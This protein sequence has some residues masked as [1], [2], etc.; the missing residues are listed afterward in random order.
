MITLI[1]NPF[2]VNEGSITQQ[3][4]YIQDETIFL[5][6]NDKK[7]YIK[8]D[9]IIE[10]EGKYLLPGIIDDQVHFREPGLTQKGDIAT[11][12]KA[13]VA[14]GVTSYMEMPNTIPQTITIKLLEE[15]YK[16]AHNNSLANYS[17][18]LGATN[19]NFDEIKKIDQKKVCGV[20]VFLGSSTGNMLVNEPEALK[21]IFSCRDLLI[22]V[23]CEDENIVKTNTDKYKNK[24]GENVPIKYHPLIRSEAACFKSS[25]FAVSLA[26]KYGTRLHVI[27]LSTKKE[28]SLF[29][30]KVSLNNKRI[31]SE[32]CVHH[33][34]FSDEDYSEKG[35][36]IKWN[37][38]IKT[39]E[40]RD[41]LF[42]G[43]L[44]NKI[45]VIAT[46][47]SP[48]LR[49]EKEN[50][51]FY[52]PSGGPLVQHSL[53]AMLEH[54]HHKKISL[55]K[56]VEKMCHAPACLFRIDKRG[57][58]RQNYFADLVL[59]DINSPQQVLPENTYYKCSWSPFDNYIFKSKVIMTL[60]NG[61]IAY[62][63]GTFNTIK[64][65]Q[66]LMFIKNNEKTLLA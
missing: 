66:R 40:D 6:T 41:A 8:A 43:L 15:K 44:N 50:S 59:V 23:H 47:H 56:I 28:L 33:L 24:Y 3:N 18:Y 29:D 16:I 7:K 31:T 25:S 27:H 39:K 64:K 20:K 42:D 4:V 19:Q 34:W 1:K 38:A 21:K 12:S 14:G 35:V 46:D 13:A 48:H 36:F 60:V 55:E 57:Y 30:E 65:G 17:F 5:I 11:E 61:H 51:Y 37:P 49:E 62:N 22:A 32:V 9:I 10:G 63:Q 53:V 45:D 54:Y 26:K 2:V 52:S 58:I